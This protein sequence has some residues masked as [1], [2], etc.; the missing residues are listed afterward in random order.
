MSI[1]MSLPAASNKTP[2]SVKSYKSPISIGSPSTH[3]SNKS[4]FSIA[5]SIDRSNNNS[6]NLNSNSAVHKVQMKTSNASSI[7]QVDQ[8]KAG[9]D[10]TALCKFE[11]KSEDRELSFEF[12]DLIKIINIIAKD[13]QWALGE[14]RGEKGFLL[15]KYVKSKSITMPWF[16]ENMTREQAEFLLKDL[17]EGSYLMRESTHYPG[18]FTL[19]LKSDLKIENYHIKLLNK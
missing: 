17:P 9:S 8:I 6:S 18:D 16:H 2:T 15:L 4:Q 12:G 11:G 19:C 13:P 5:K 7:S 10:V 1:E 14:L 3:S